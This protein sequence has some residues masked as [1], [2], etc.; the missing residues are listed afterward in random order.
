VICTTAR[1]PCAAGR[2]HRAGR[3]SRANAE[4][5]IRGYYLY[6]PRKS[7][8]VIARRRSGV[9][10]QPESRR[11]AIRVEWMGKVVDHPKAQIHRQRLDR[12]RREA[13]EKEYRRQHRKDLKK[14]KS[15][16]D[17]LKALKH[18]RYQA[19]NRV[20]YAIE[21]GASVLAKRQHPSPEHSKAAF[22]KAYG[23]LT[24]KAIAVVEGTVAEA[25]GFA[26]WNEFQKAQG[27]A[28]DDEADA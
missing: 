5:F 26:T 13:E 24:D 1:S 7:E 2:P 22:A 19:A 18:L 17:R 28:D 16:R 14:T 3:V 12:Q 21:T 20:D 15:E 25:A 4:K 6:L 27:L 9:Q 23:D 10:T 11:S 8:E